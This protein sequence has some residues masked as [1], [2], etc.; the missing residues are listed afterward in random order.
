MDKKYYSPK[1][2]ELLWKFQGILM[3]SD[4]DDDD[5]EVYVYDPNDPEHNYNW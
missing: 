1:C 4:G 2:D 5:T 3:E